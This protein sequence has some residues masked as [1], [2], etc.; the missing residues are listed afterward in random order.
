MRRPQS[1][2]MHD[3]D[4]TLAMVQ[5]GGEEGGELMPRFVA[6][7]SV[8]VDFILGHPASPPQIAQ[9]R[10]GQSMAQVVRFVTAFQPVLQGDRAVQAFMQG[11]AFVGEML[12]WTGWRRPRAVRYEIGRWKGLDA[13]HRCAELGLLRGEWRGRWRIVPVGQGAPLCR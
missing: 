8:Q 5:A 12:Q 1:L 7:Q 13:G 3:P 11:G 2:A 10:L 6:V 4:A 9:Y